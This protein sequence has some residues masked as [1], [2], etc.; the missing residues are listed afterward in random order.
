MFYVGYSAY[1]LHGILTH[2]TR[3]KP[4]KTKAKWQNA[5]FLTDNANNHEKCLETKAL[6]IK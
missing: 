4:Q 5:K 6:S 2:T 1:S 3:K